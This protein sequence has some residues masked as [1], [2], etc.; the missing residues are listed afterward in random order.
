MNKLYFYVDYGS[1]VDAFFQPKNIDIFLIFQ[2]GA[3]NVFQQHIFP[4]RNNNKKISQQGTSNEYLK[5]IIKLQI[6]AA[7]NEYSHTG[8]DKCGYQV[9]SFLISPPKHMLWV[10][11]RSAL[12]QYFWTEKKACYQEL[13]HNICFPGEIRKIFIGYPSNL[14]LSWLLHI[15]LVKAFFFNP[16]VLKFFLFL[17]ENIC[18]GT[19]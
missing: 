13:C 11:I 14:E 12:H 9:Y 5:A 15:A 6:R 16:K 8:L 4:R 10:L 2:R 7:S 17:H 1:R 3:S 19:Y 18:C